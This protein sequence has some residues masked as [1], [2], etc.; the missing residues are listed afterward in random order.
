[1]KTRN[2]PELD[3]N[4]LVPRYRMHNQIQITPPDDIRRLAAWIDLNAIFYGSYDPELQAAQLAGK[5]IPMP[6]TQ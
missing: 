4:D 6:E 3:A 2:Q 1:M 5:A